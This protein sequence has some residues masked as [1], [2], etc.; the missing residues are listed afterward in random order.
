[1]LHWHLC[2]TIPQ[3]KNMVCYYMCGQEGFVVVEETSS[4]MAEYLVSMSLLS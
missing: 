3:S 4:A 1:M 2:N